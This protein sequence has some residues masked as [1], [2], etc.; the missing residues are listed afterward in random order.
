MAWYEVLADV[1]RRVRRRKVA[2]SSR[3]CE[4][5]SGTSNRFP[6]CKRETWY[7]AL[8]EREE[9]PDIRFANSGMTAFPSG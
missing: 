8:Q 5:L 7:L 2:P 4:A 9:I 3:K 6:E 1:V